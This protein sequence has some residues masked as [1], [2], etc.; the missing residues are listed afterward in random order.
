MV[1]LSALG[2]NS[3]FQEHWESIVQPG[4]EPVRVAEQQKES[5]RVVGETG[6]IT[7]EVSGRFRHTAHDMSAFPAVGDWAAVSSHGGRGLIRAVLPRRTKLSRKAAGLRTDEQVLVA[8]VDAVLAVTSLNQDLSARRMERYLSAIWESGAQPVLVLNKADLCPNPREAAAEIAAVAP[9]V[10]IHV[11]SAATGEGFDDLGSYIGPGNTVV[12]VGSSGVGKSTIINRLLDSNVQSTRDIRSSDETGRHATTYRRLFMLPGGGV[13]IDTPGIRELQ[14]WDAGEGLDET[15][16]DIGRLAAECRFRD[17]Q[18]ETE[19]GCA[20]RDAIGASRLESYRKLKR[21]LQHLDRR[22][23]A[24]AQSE[25]K[26][27][28]KQR[29]KALRIFYKERE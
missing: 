16:E 7:A 3:Y 13:L 24:A 19:P 5:Y 20:V 23:D 10:N 27:I 15:F 18:H 29:N 17:C 11:V 9:G 1:H 26:K 22:R 8:N 28:W 12:L 14:L 21:E 2:W 6:E 25:Q 4:W